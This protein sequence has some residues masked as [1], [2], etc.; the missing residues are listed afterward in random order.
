M[1]RP[2]L[3]PQ[4]PPGIMLLLLLLL[5]RWRR[6]TPQLT[7]ELGR[8]ARI[9]IVRRSRSR[10]RSR[11]SILLHVAQ[12]LRGLHLP[13]PVVSVPFLHLGH[14][15]LPLSLP[16]P[17]LDRDAI[18]V[19]TRRAR[20]HFVLVLRRYGRITPGRQ[21]CEI[22]R[23]PRCRRAV[24]LEGARRLGLWWARRRYAHGLSGCWRGGHEP[25]AD[26]ARVRVLV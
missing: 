8:R 12:L 5:L 22:A 14:L 15:E 9:V 4:I 11:A 6:P 16:L 1:L 7:A 3:P 23:I 20:L 10:A 17:H 18:L 26:R 21:L 25:A 13:H 24:A 19:V 2:Q